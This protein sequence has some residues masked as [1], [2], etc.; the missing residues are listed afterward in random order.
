M[1]I[2]RRQHRIARELLLI[3]VDLFVGGLGDDHTI[4]A[5]Q[6][7]VEYVVDMLKR[8]QPGFFSAP[9][10]HRRGTMSNDN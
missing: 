9:G 4:I 10:D 3:A 2:Q 1:T 5:T 6:R 7:H 8:K